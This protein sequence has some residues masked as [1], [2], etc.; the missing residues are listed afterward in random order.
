MRP[1]KIDNNPEQQAFVRARSDRHTFVQIAQAVAKA[2]PE[3]RRVGKSA[4]HDRWKRS[5]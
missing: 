4:I 2:C 1:A 3:N 5:A